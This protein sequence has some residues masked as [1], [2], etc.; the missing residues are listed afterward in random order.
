VK[1]GQTDP[2]AAECPLVGYGQSGEDCPYSVIV[3]ILG[4]YLA[5]FDI[6]SKLPKYLP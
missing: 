4:T 2:S 5:L 3:S 1:Y 6:F